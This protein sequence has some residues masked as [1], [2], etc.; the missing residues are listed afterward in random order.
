MMNTTKK[1]KKEKRKRKT[2]KMKKKKKRKTLH[3]IETVNI[4]VLQ[5]QCGSC[6][7]FSTTGS[8]EGQY[9][10]KTGTL[11]SFS[12]QEL[13][14]CSGSYG[15]MG[16]NGGLMDQA[17][18]YLEK[19]GAEKESDYPYTA[20]V[21]SNLNGWLQGCMYI[22]PSRWRHHFTMLWELRLFSG[23]KCDI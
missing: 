17:F 1:K 9:F 21:S 18:E 10:A 19:Y 3:V 22:V 6:W 23:L 2:N 5:G 4:F 7:S 11:V 15:N 8:L 13:V 12:E 14:D 16:C 20:K